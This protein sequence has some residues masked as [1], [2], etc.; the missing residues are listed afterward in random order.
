MKA[1]WLLAAFASAA[2]MN[3]S[4][5]SSNAA[6]LS[7]AAF[8]T[9]VKDTRIVEEVRRRHRHHRRHHRHRR[10]YGYGYGYGLPYIGRHFGHHRR[11]RG[12]GH[13]RRHHHGH[14]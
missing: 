2:I 11:H 7:P 9:V 8:D 12:Y 1:T 4:G 5:T 6:P 3:L 14:H 13:H 10:F